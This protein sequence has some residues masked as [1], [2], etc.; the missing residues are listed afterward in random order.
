M[1]QTEKDEIMDLLPLH[2][3]KGVT[4]IEKTYMPRIIVVTTSDFYLD[5]STLEELVAI[6]RFIGIKRKQDFSGNKLEY[7]FKSEGLR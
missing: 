3:K 4:G 5:K 6:E 7:Q 2:L 1:E